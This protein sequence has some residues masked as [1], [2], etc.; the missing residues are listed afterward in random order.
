MREVI[1]HYED[2]PED[3]RLLTGWGQLEFARTQEIILRH[4]PPAPA[5]VLDVGGGSGIYSQWLGT[6]G[7]ETHLVEPV[8]RH[9]ESACQC[10][11]I[12]GAEVG[13]A[14]RLAQ[15]DESFDAVLLLGPL[16]HLT[17]S[18]ERLQALGEARRVLRPGGILVAAAINH[19]ASLL[20]GLVLGVVDDARFAPI[21][22]QDLE[23]G[24]HRNPTDNPLYFTTAFFHKPEELR[25]ETTGAGFHVRDLV[26]VEG[27]FWLAKGFDARWSD[28]ERREQ[29]LR[30]ARKVEHEPALLGASLHLLVVARRG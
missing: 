28:P 2:C 13:D 1:A 22:E 10:K 23:N 27:A 5:R 15:T 18:T 21:L 9:V 4:L 14:R 19:F 30:L 3:S 11:E 16:Y 7:Y 24:Q 29:L 12:A 17:D 8:R 20:Q 26:A 6:L 25:A